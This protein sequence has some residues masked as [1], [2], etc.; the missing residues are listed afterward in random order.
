MELLQKEKFIQLMGNNH[1]IPMIVNNYR[2]YSWKGDIYILDN[3]LINITSTINN[4]LIDCIYN[5]LINYNFKLDIDNCIKLKYDHL[6]NDNYKNPRYLEWKEKFL[7]LIG[8]NKTEPRVI[9]IKTLNGKD[10]C[11]FES[12]INWYGIYTYKKDVYI[13]HLG[14]DFN[15]SVFDDDILQKLYKKL[16]NNDFEI[17]ESY[18]G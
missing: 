6:I 3:N 8:D 14:A 1:I 11:T 18:Q 5:S 12:K 7:D 17:V 13:L 2:I 4:D 9:Y 10:E 15:I 16:K